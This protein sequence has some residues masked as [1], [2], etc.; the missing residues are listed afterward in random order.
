MILIAT[1][2]DLPAVWARIDLPLLD[3]IL[4]ALGAGVL[5]HQLQ[6]PIAAHWAHF[7]DRAAEV[8]KGFSFPT[9][10][11]SVCGLGG[12]VEGSAGRAYSPVAVEADL[13]GLY[14]LIH[15]SHPP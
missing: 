8:G 2:A 11:A 13:L 6:L 9:L 1:E 5:G 10:W 15:S 7:G 12:R 14:P 3:L 4:P